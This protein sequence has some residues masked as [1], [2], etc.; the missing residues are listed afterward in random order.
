MFRERVLNFWRMSTLEKKHFAEAVCTAY[1]Y[2][3]YL[4]FVPFKTWSK[5]QKVEFSEHRPADAELVSIRKALQRARRFN[6][7]KNQCLV[8]SL[9]GKSMLNRRK[10]ASELH[11]GLKKDE[12]GRLVAHAWLEVQG[13]IL[14]ETEDN[15][16][17][18]ASKV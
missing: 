4:F 1:Y 17:K 7:W 2:K 8:M 18:I 11:L 14:I 10:I 3:I 12:N 15:Y 13:F 5:R 6:P 9:S 16:L